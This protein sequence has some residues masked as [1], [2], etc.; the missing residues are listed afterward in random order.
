[1]KLV[2]GNVYYLKETGEPLIYDRTTEDGYHDFLGLYG[3]A[4]IPKKV[5]DKNPSILSEQPDDLEFNAIGE[6]IRKFEEGKRRYI[7]GT[8]EEKVKGA[9]N[10]LESEHIR[11]DERYKKKLNRFLTSLE[12]VKLMIEQVERLSTHK[13]K[14]S[15]LKQ[16]KAIIDNSLQPTVEQEIENT[17][18]GELPF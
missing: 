17:D 1:M 16:I 5:L 15:L 8:T 7:A 6:F 14:Q 2:K 9:I 4:S 11:K 3:N 10:Y 12:A 13:Q 18:D